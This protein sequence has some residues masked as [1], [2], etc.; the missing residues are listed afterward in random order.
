MTIQELRRAVMESMEQERKLC[1]L[2]LD[3]DRFKRFN[4]KFGHQTGD[5]VLRLVARTI[6]EGVKGKD[7]TAR[8]GGEEFA[9]ILGATDLNNAVKVGE[10]I[11][12]QVATKRIINRANGKDLGQITVSVGAS[13]YQYGEPLDQFIERADQALYFAKENGRNRVCSETDVT[14]GRR[15]TPVF[16]PTVK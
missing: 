6:K 3:I 13:E 11:C 8:Y 7:V 10:A 12:Q 2:M 4:D 5:Q 14:R 16:E 15:K 9:V 1:L